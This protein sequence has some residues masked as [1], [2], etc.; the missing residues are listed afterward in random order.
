VGRPCFAWPPLNFCVSLLH[1]CFAP[2]ARTAVFLGREPIS[3]ISAPLMREQV[4]EARQQSVVWKW[5]LT[6]RR[7]THANTKRAARPGRSAHQPLPGTFMLGYTGL[8]WLQPTIQTEVASMLSPSICSG[9][10]PRPSLNLTSPF[11]LTVRSTRT[12]MLRIIAG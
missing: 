8:S 11:R 3:P 12:I 7:H 4:F 5:P 10:G 9:F 6:W 1:L 2:S